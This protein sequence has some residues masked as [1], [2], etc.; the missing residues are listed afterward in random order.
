MSF[1][2]EYWLRRRVNHE[3]AL[4]HLALTTKRKTKSF[5]RKMAE[6]VRI[7]KECTTQLDKNEAKK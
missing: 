4:V 1:D 3:N 5:D 7:L 2:R 6:I